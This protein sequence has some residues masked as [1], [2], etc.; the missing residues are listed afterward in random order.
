[1]GGTYEYGIVHIYGIVSIVYYH[2][3]HSSRE[4]R[5]RKKE[6]TRRA[7]E[8]LFFSFGWWFFL[9]AK[10]ESSFGHGSVPLADK[11]ERKKWRMPDLNWRP[12]GLES[13][14]LPTE[15][16]LHRWGKEHFCIQLL[17]Y[18]RSWFPASLFE[19][20]TSY[21][22]NEEIT[23]TRGAKT[24]ITSFFLVSRAFP[25][26]SILFFLSSSSCP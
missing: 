1:M 6:T 18:F 8:L 22:I 23:R 4:R 21:I 7:T 16:I 20:A 24:N 25:L 17:V 2:T 19:K 15:L 13:N 10:K 14:A 26:L 3:I 12:L 5:R 11:I 9:W